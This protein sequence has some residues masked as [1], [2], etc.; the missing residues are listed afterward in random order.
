MTRLLSY[1]LICLFLFSQPAHAAPIIGVLVALGQ[2]FAASITVKAL[3]AAALKTLITTAI[4]VLME[5]YQKSKRRDPGLVTTHTT[6]GGID[7]Q[8]TIIG[9]YAT[10]GHAVYQ[11]GF[12]ANNIYN[13]HVVEVGDLPGARLR[14]LIIDG[15]ISEIGTDWQEPYGY[16][17]ETKRH[18]STSF[19]GFIRFLDG[20]QIAADPELVARFKDD[21]ERPWTDDHILTGVCYAVLTFYHMAYLY[22]NGRPE[23]LF[24]LDGPGFYD[25]RQDSTVGGNGPQRWDAPETWEFTDNAMV[26]A[27]HILR[28]ITLPCGRIYGGDFDAEDLPLPDWF[29]AMNAREFID[30]N[31]DPQP[32][33]C[34]YE[35]KFEEAPADILKELFAAANAQI[36]EIGGYWYPIVGDSGDA[37]AEIVLDTDLSVSDAWTHDPFPDLNSTFNGVIVSH[38]SPEALWNPSTLETISKANWIAEDGRE[39]LYD[40]SLPMVFD[41]N[42]GRQIGDAL[43]KENRR[44][45]AH[46]WPMLPEFFR[47]RPLQTINATSEDYEYTSKSFRITEVAYDLLTLNVSIS[48]RECDPEDYNPDPA[49]ALPTVPQVTSTPSPTHSGVTGFAVYGAAIKDGAG[50]NR[51]PAIRIVWDGDI[52]DA[53]DGL[54]FR[55]KVVGTSEIIT[56]STQDVSAGEFVF[57]PTIRATDYVV[58][59]KPVARNRATSWSAWLPVTTPDVGIAPADLSTETFETLS[60]AA[61]DVASVLDDEL[62]AARIDPLDTA[63]EV[64]AVSQQ[65]QADAL[66]Q[67]GEQSLWALTHLAGLDSLMAD[68]GIVIDPETGAVR[69]Y[70]L[71]AEGERISQVELRMSAAEGTINL[72]ATQAWVNQQITL[73][74]LDPSSL[75]LVDDLQ[76]QLNQVEIDLD[77]AEAALALMA[78]QTTVT[79][80]D[81]RL[82]Q[83]EL[84]LDA[85]EAAITLKASQSEFTGLQDRLQSA[86]IQISAMDGPQISQTVAD[87]RNQQTAQDL[88][89]LATLEQLLQSYE[90]REA[91]RVDLAYASQDLRAHVDDQGEAFAAQTAALGAVTADNAALIEAERT[92]RASETAAIAQDIVQLDA[93]LGGA[94][95]TLAGHSAAISELATEIELVDGVVAA[96]ATALTAVQAELDGA[97]DTLAG[98]SA[99]ISELTTE[100]ELVDGVVAAQATALTAVQAEVDGNS[101]GVSQS[102]AAIGGINAEYTLQLDVNGVISGLVVRSELDDEGAVVSDTVFK[103]D[104][105]AIVG[106]NGSNRTAP[107][108]VYTSSRTIDGKLFPAGV[109]MENVFLG[110]A[111]IGRAQIEDTIQSDDYAEDADG[112]PTAGLKLDF[113]TGMVKAAGVVLS[114]PMVL[115]TGSFTLTGNI[116]DGD[117][118]AFV[119]TGI[120]VGKSDVWQASSVALVAAASVTTGAT[121]PGGFDPNN[122]LWSLNA[123][124]QPGA[125]WNGFGG[126]NPDPS[127]NWQKDPNKLVTPYWSSGTDQRVFLKIDLEATQGVYFSNPK[128]EWTV[129]QVT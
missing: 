54:A 31:G 111:S 14:R 22:P 95:D 62:V 121:A 104:R 53:T 102:L 120:R 123:S 63:L 91:W 60:D 61:F 110:R 65:T 46:K 9:R 117:Q 125:R 81:A 43:L 79:G 11:N 35:I 44:F 103:S 27:Y 10:G 64:Q 8:A 80:I 12:G 99:A 118:W 109:Y 68:A 94:G 105:F 69:I 50:N 51:A 56:A 88:A 106:P 55:V 76:L 42:Q 20:S 115:A 71:E 23:Y 28:G 124:I 89:D 3:V 2:A 7:P 26:I 19:T 72:A 108:V 34:G 75:P 59:A 92:A 5:K 48:V 15:E 87:T 13:V 78:S 83:A 93:Q 16:P 98:H 116:Q 1:A 52:A 24:E 119:N 90:N 66:N 122:A 25:P 33:R 47:L 128:I 126:A 45:R 21:P 30:E 32:A 36:V 18:T 85:A 73:A 77:A 129:F 113:A 70:G 58:Q 39:K 127:A 67:I 17:I 101:A 40:L 57:A 86:E 100:I 29:A 97:G 114:R 96:Q 107:F 74:A 49:L 4:S 84:D 82:S 112:I 6:K 38:P 41:A 37:V